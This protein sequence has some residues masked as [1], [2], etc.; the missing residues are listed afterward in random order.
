MKA[1]KGVKRLRHELWFDILESQLKQTPYLLYKDACNEKSN[2]KSRDTKSSNLCTEGE[3]IQI[4]MNPQ[5]NNLGLPD[6]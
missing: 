3:N 5:L 6:L 1:S 2:Q 4:K